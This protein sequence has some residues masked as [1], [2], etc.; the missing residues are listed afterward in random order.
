MTLILDKAKTIT[1][2]LPKH[3]PTRCAWQQQAYRYSRPSLFWDIMQLRLVV[4]DVSGQHNCPSSRVN[5]Q[6]V[7]T[8]IWDWQSVPKRRLLPINGKCEITEMVIRQNMLWKFGE[9][10]EER[11][12]IC[13]CSVLI[14]FLISTEIRH[15]KG[16]LLCKYF[17]FLHF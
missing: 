13:W 7:E 4:I 3:Q 14:A 10:A 16:E 11:Y 8:W 2:H 9:G 1:A 17:S 5:S 15:T 12:E 6:R